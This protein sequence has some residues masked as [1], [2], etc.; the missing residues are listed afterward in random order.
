MTIEYKQ[1]T[2][3]EIRGK[4]EVKNG[5][6]VKMVMQ[7]T[8]ESCI[9]IFWLD[10]WQGNYQALQRQQEAHLHV[11][12]VLLEWHR[13]DPQCRNLFKYEISVRI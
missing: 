12:V 7:L 13:Y 8:S 6:N 4:L 2:I 10:Q 5:Y 1:N 3:Q 9:W 11:S